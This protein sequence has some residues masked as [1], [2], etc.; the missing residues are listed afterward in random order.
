MR[1]PLLGLI[2]T[3]TNRAVSACDILANRLSH[4]SVLVL[5]DWP[6]RIDIGEGRAFAEWVPSVPHLK[7]EFLFL[8]TWGHL[9][10]RVWHRDRPVFFDEHADGPAV[11]D[12]DASDFFGNDA[13]SALKR[14]RPGT[15]H[16]DGYQNCYE[17][18][19]QY[20]D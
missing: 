10:I 14:S 9:Y 8:G 15:K 12:I 19:D 7:F 20:L 5:D 18:G 13:R 2:V 17:A 6:H 11:V 3:F 16:S 1:S 4:G